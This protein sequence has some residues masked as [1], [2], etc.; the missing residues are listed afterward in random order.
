MSNRRSAWIF[1]LELCRSKRTPP[2]ASIGWRTV[3][4]EFVIGTGLC[5]AYLDRGLAALDGLDEVLGRELE[6]LGARTGRRFGDPKRP[7]L[8]SVRSGAPVSMPG[9]ME[10]L[11]NI[12]LTSATL[13]GLLRLTGNPHLAADWWRRLVQQFAEVIQ[14]KD[15]KPFEKILAARL[16][17][18][19]L[20]HVEELDSEALYERAAS[21][22]EECRTLVGEEFP[23]EPAVQLSA[24][25]EAILKSWI[26][27]SP[28]L[29]MTS[30]PNSLGRRLPR[31]RF[32]GRC[33]QV[34]KSKP[35]CATGFADERKL[36]MKT[37]MP[38]DMKPSRI[39]GSQVRDTI[40]VAGNAEIQE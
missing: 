10:T 24:S 30:R 8:V 16:K 17:K 38:T 37:M 26:G 21:F 27:V 4:P 2:S 9:M 39:I 33:T 36:V 3:P 19:G 14:D 7:L 34:R 18:D 1:E 11:L 5:R 6:A 12:G 22:E 25:V 40:I 23:S 13:R 29:L 20:A 35:R 28:P 31:L 32:W 15:R